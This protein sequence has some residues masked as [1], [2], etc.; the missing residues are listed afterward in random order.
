MAFPHFYAHDYKYIKQEIQSTLV[1][2][3]LGVTLSHLTI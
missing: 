2:C 3:E 1:V